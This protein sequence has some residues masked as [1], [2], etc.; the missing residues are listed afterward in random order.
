MKISCAVILSFLCSFELT[1]SQELV[2][3]Q[4][5][6]KEVKESD[7][8]QQINGSVIVV[9]QVASDLL[10]LLLLFRILLLFSVGI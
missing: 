5:K 6:A 7:D 4:I 10:Y 2:Q 8:R 1:F 3:Y 9:L